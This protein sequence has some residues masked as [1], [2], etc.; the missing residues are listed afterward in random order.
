MSYGQNLVHGKGTSLSR[1][2][3]Y[4]FCSGGTLDKPSWGYRFGY[5]FRVG[6]YRFFS[7]GNPTTLSILLWSYLILS[8]THMYVTPNSLGRIL[9]DWETD[10]F[11]HV[12]FATGFRFSIKTARQESEK[13]T[14]F[15]WPALTW[16]KHIEWTSKKPAGTR[17]HLPIPMFLQLLSTT[18]PHRI[19]NGDRETTSKHHL[20]TKDFGSL[21]KVEEMVVKYTGKIATWSNILCHT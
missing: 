6:P 15:L 16:K 12:S 9:G 20:L 14:R 7:D 8:D 4:R 5:R 19:R 18:K 3:P 21:K 1:V 2:G 13:Q 10:F 11:L 17:V